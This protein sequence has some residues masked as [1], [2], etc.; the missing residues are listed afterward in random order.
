MSG[1][2]NVYQYD[3]RVLYKFIPNKSF[4]QL[5]GISPKSFIFL[6]TI[7]S[8]F[9]YFEVWFTDQNSKLLEIE[10]KINIT[11]VII[12]IP[13]AI[14]L[15]QKIKYLLKAVDHFCL[16]LKIDKLKSKSLSGRYSQKPLNHAKR[17]ATDALKATSKKVIQKRAEVTGDLI[18][19]IGFNKEIPKEIY[20]SPEKKT[21]NY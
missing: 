19:S 18:E 5:L 12:K 14:Q 13:P 3:L 8:E 4:G 2:N 7:N 20:I 1:V 17:A 16:L 9:S 11:L 10:G 15:N 21:T 6:K